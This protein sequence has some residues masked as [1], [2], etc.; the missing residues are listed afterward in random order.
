MSDYVRFPVCRYVI[1]VCHGVVY[2]HLCGDKWIYQ[3][4]LWS[5]LNE[6]FGP[7]LRRT[8]WSTT[9]S[10]SIIPISLSSRATPTA[11]DRKRKF[12][13]VEGRQEGGGL[14]MPKDLTIEGLTPT[15]VERRLVEARVDLVARVWGEY[16]ALFNHAVLCGL[17]LPYRRPPEDQRVFTRSQGGMTLRI[18]AGVYP[19]ATGFKDIG[20]PYGPRARLLLL[21]LCSQA[22]KS[23]SPIVEVA[24]SF[25]AFARSLGLATTGRNLRTL[26]EQVNRMAVVHMRFSRKTSD[27]VEVFQGPLFSKLRAE[28]PDD[29]SQLSLF[30]SYVEF[31]PEFYQSLV[32][33]AVPLRLEAIGALKHSSRGLDIYCWLAH[34]LWRITGGP[35]VSIKWTTLRWQFGNR[36]QDLGSFKRAFKAALKQVLVVY[37][38][39]RVEIIKGGLLLFRSPPPVGQTKSVGLLL[40]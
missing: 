7:L 37:P 28:Y 10:R 13:E 12:N 33:H 34:R 15:A 9:P 2:Q 36:G 11:V 25:T 5:T 21:H 31:S 24:D 16:D 29:P 3:R 20:I 18:E 32:N 4:T 39:A 19:T 30:S 17:G 8:L 27:Y 14:A 1:L 22:V 6:H 38:E 35:S 23:Q 26:R 40:K